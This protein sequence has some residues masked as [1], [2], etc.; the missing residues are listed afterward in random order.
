[1]KQREAEKLRL[2]RES[3][4]KQ[5]KNLDEIEK[6]LD[7]IEGNQNAHASTEGTSK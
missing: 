3:L 2:L 7:E 4:D 5:R 1:M 6:H